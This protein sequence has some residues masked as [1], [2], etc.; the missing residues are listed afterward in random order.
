MKLIFNNNYINAN[1]ILF[2]IVVVSIIIMIILS[3]IFARKEIKNEY[4]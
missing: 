1:P 3:I 2:W 4:K